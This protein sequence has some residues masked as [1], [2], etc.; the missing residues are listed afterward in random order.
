MADNIRTTPL[1]LRPSEHRTILFI[2]DLLMAVASVFAAIETWRRFNISA[3][4]AKL[5]AERG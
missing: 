4:I 1:R 3:E 5:V 2:G